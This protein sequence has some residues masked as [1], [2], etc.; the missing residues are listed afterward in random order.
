MPVAAMENELPIAYP[1]EGRTD[2]FELR[3]IPLRFNCDPSHCL[4]V[5]L[6]A[7]RSDLD[8]W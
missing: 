8:Q 4:K 6:R 5:L 2:F 7:D 3:Q 1:S